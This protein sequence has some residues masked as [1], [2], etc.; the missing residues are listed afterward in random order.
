MSEKQEQKKKYTADE[1]FALTA[2]N[3]LRCELY[4]GEIISQAVPSL[5]HQII[6]AELY[7]KFR[8]FIKSRNGRCRALPPIDVK[9]DEYNTVVPDFLLV[10]DPSKLDERRCYGA[11]DFVAE[12]LSLNSENDLI[13]KLALY[14][15]YGVREY[16]IISPRHR[17][18]LVYF[19]EESSFPQIFSFEKL[20]PVNIY[21]GEFEINVSELIKD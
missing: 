16:W 18:T 20:I 17:K 4:N 9:L 2:E 19:F 10:C 8:D 21:D 14:K 13:T 11:P 3:S 7:V 1:F 5:E 15:Q 12:I 6:R